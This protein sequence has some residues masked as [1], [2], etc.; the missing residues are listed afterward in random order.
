MKTKVGTENV[1]QHERYGTRDLSFSAFHREASLARFVGLE[2]AKLI[3]TIDIDFAPALAPTLWIEYREHDRQVLC[4]VETSIDTGRQDHKPAT[5]ITA[6]AKRARVPAY[7]ILYQRSPKQNP[8]DPRF[9]DL[10]AMHIKRLHP[11]PDREW[12][13]FTPQQYAEKLIAL[14]EWVSKRIDA[15]AANDPFFEVQPEQGSLFG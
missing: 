15:E 14:R 10:E 2:R 8:A 12:R 11:R 9:Q 6:L 7:L 5:V 13:Q 3:S 1:P 4:L